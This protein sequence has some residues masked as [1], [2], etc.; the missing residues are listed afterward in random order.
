MAL[1]R[2][3]PPDNA[4]RVQS[5]GGNL[6]YTLANKAGRI[7]QCESFQER[8][9]ALLLERDPTVRDY[10]SQPEQIKWTD[11]ENK[12]HTYIPDFIVWRTD[13]T[14]ELHEVTLTQ[15]Q[16]DA[17]NQARQAAAQ[18][19]CQTRG[20]T[21][22]VHTEMDLPNEAYTANLFALYAYR[23]TSYLDATLTE[24][25]VTLINHGVHRVSDLI[26]QLHAETHIVTP[27]IYANLL[28][29]LWQ[30]WIVTDLDHLLFHDGLLRPDCCF[31]VKRE[32]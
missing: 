13:D 11:P 5:M 10:G 2:K 19:I 17:H 4:R 31:Q 1:K 29:L 24:P 25:V 9:L 20:W 27:R 30:G 26:P 32:A 21:Y 22:K 8:K 18:A 16:G 12:R 7:V 15:R 28:H 23:S 14:I 6:R 3:P